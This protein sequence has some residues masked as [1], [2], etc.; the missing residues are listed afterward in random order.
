MYMNIENVTDADFENLWTHSVDH[1]V[2]STFSPYVITQDEDGKYWTDVIPN[3]DLKTYI[4]DS[5]QQDT[6]MV[7]R[8]HDA[9]VA[10]MVISGKKEDYIWNAKY[11]MTGPKEGSTSM[12]WLYHELALV[13]YA[14]FKEITEHSGVLGMNITTSSED[15]AVN[16]FLIRWGSTRVG[17]SSRGGPMWQTR[18]LTE[19]ED[20][21]PYD[22]Q[23]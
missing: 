18:W 12:L 17:T 1:M 22:L 15:S 6:C 11:F 4:K 20:I 5:I 2:S 7:F 8:E 16:A 23:T 13:S 9:A 10:C 21:I 19:R 3:I 14:R